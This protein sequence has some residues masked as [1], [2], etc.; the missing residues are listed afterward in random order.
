MNL[1]E[2]FNPY[3]KSLES[4]IRDENWFLATMGACTLPDICTSL[5]DKRGNGPY[6][7]WFNTYVKAYQPTVNR[8]KRF[9]A[10]TLEEWINSPP[11]KPEDVGLETIVFFSG[12]NAYALRCAFLHGGN[13]DLSLQ[14]VQSGER[15]FERYK[16]QIINIKKVE[17]INDPTITIDKDKENGIAYLN[18]ERYCR[19]I[20]AGVI[21]WIETISELKTSDKPNE[22]RVYSIVHENASKMIKFE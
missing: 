16:D 21:N 19:A 7:E 20:I 18:P 3:I 22:Q 8:R 14:P 4:G 5:E 10:E 17:F 15:R 6:I 1:E 13:G 11:Y 9:I 2:V 12:V